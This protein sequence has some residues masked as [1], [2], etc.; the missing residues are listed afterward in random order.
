M[1]PFPPGRHLARGGLW[2]I[3]VLILSFGLSSPGEGAPRPPLPPPAA[4]S[5]IVPPPERIADIDAMRLLAGLLAEKPASRP[6]AVSWW[7]RIVRTGQAT[8]ADVAALVPL[9][10]AQSSHA[11]AESILRMV[12]NRFPRSGRLYRLLGNAFLAQGRAPAAVFALE[13]AVAAAPTDAEAVLSLGRALAACGAFAR[14]EEVLGEKRTRADSP[15]AWVFHEALGAVFLQQQQWEQALAAFVQSLQG[16]PEPLETDGTADAPRLRLQR[17]IAFLHSRLNHLIEADGL[18]KTVLETAP[19]DLDVLLERA[20]VLRRLARADDAVELLEAQEAVFASATEFLAELADAH[21][22]LGHVARCRDLYRRLLPEISPSGQTAW[23]RR[24]AN[25]LLQFGA[26]RPAINLM[27]QVIAAA[28]ARPDDRC[29]LAWMLAS[30]ERYEEAGQQYRKVLAI[31]PT[32][33]EALLGRIKIRLL[34]R[35]FAAAAALAGEARACL[36]EDAEWCG[37][38]AEAL[39]KSGRIDEAR[40]VLFRLAIRDRLTPEVAR[41][42]LLLLPRCHVDGSERPRLCRSFVGSLAAVPGAELERRFWEADGDEDFARE[43]INTTGPTPMQISRVADLYAAR[44]NASAAISLYRVVLARDPEVLAASV[45]LALLLGATRRFQPALHLVNNLLKRFPEND[46]IR[47]LWARLLSW[48]RSYDEAIEAYRELARSD[49]G[50]PVPLR[51]GARAAF[52]G[53]RYQAG[54][55]LYAQLLTPPVDRLVQQDLRIAA[56]EMGDL[57]ASQAL[58]LIGRSMRA[59]EPYAGYEVL[60]QHPRPASASPPIAAGVVDPPG[61]VTHVLETHAFLY[62]IQKSLF[63]ELRGKNGVRTGRFRRGLLTFTRLVDW[64]PGNLEARF[65]VSQL[66]AMLGLVDHERASYDD[67]L[68]RDP[69][70]NL[71]GHALATLQRRHRPIL[72]FQYEQAAETGRGDLARMARRT[73]KFSGSTPLGPRWWVTATRHWSRFRPEHSGL[74][75]RSHGLSLDLKGVLSPW[76]AAEAGLSNNTFAGST[77]FPSSNG[78]DRSSWYVN[79]VVRL[80]DWAD[81]RLGFDR[82][83][84]YPNEV[85]LRQGTQA[86]TTTMALHLNCSR[87]LALQGRWRGMRFSDD[88]RSRRFFWE[89][90]YALT[91][92]PE[93]FKVILSGEHI[94]TDRPTRYLYSGGVLTDIVHPYWTPGRYS[95]RMLTLEYFRD[96]S[97]ILITRTEHSFIDLRVSLGTDSLHNP[98]RRVEAVWH[99][100]FRHRWVFEARGTWHDSSDWKERTGTLWIGRHF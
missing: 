45:N 39:L 34:A 29:A 1:G 82:N 64:M 78:P 46:K 38:L 41:A 73:W 48:S 94:R 63:L 56:E 8:E 69:Q 72:R 89:A 58:N 30:A 100:E 62:E 83:E 86:D 52:W 37:L 70:H 14:A 10:I 59:T 33:R 23:N 17:Q 98:A 54:Q 85:A 99:T 61:T 81:L 20:R 84:V 66:Q 28:D 4:G 71:V 18:L 13:R 9:L 80:H 26:F 44:G 87:R 7:R 51:E 35:D 88:N 91:D 53:K 3:A 6:E 79:A 32:N 74:T 90:G 19:R 22:D 95:S 55:R 11:E 50:N 42:G 65:D 49:P 16:L 12:L 68:R 77:L 15:G 96:Y 40:S 97:P 67:I 24:W 27:R 60:A 5:S 57:Q 21:L 31:D 2:L 75:V 76:V 43:L 36:A 92:H 47:L 25:H 93:I